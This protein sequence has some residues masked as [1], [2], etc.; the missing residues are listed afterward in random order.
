MSG[1]SRLLLSGLLGMVAPGLNAGQMMT[2]A[3]DPAYR[4]TN[5]TS[6]TGRYVFCDETYLKKTGH[7]VAHG[8]RMAAKRRNQQRHKLACKGK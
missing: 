3:V 2:A 4:R 1:L 6:T 5:V 8:K 7:S